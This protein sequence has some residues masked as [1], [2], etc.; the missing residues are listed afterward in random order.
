MQQQDSNKKV[1]MPQLEVEV[2]V[3]TRGW[4]ESICFWPKI[5]KLK[6]EARQTPIE[7]F[8]GP[9]VGCAEVKITNGDVIEF[10]TEIPWPTPIDRMFL[11]MQVYML[12]QMPN[13]EGSPKWQ[14]A[15][16]SFCESFSDF[17][18]P[19]DVYWTSEQFR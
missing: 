10:E 12:S 4:F 14:K 13:F 8:Y 9:T 17:E 5:T 3:A 16:L 7:E 18:K 15:M 2:E 19:T 6:V 1:E 11:L